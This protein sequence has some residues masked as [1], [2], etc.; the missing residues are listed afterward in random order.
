MK[1]IL[2]IF[3]SLAILHTTSPAQNNYLRST[4]DAIKMMKEYNAPGLI[5]FSSKRCNPCQR[6]HAEL[7]RTRVKGMD[8]NF[9]EALK[10]T[11]VV[12]YV[13]TD[14]EPNEARRWKVSSLPTYVLLDNGGNRILGR[15]VGYKDAHAF[16]RWMQEA[17]NKVR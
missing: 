6:L 16:V 7:E 10:Q 13:D 17:C 2:A 9:V 5:F 1:Y 3:V 12:Y 15:G 11:Y 14:N 4:D 8:I